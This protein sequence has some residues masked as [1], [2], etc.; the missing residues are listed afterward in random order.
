[1][2]SGLVIVAQGWCN[3]LVV[4]LL[5]KLQ[6]SAVFMEAKMLKFIAPLFATQDV[7]LYILANVFTVDL[8]SPSVVV[9]ARLTGTEVV[10]VSTI[11]MRSCAG[12]WEQRTKVTLH[13]VLPSHNSL[14][15]NLSN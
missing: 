7:K 11:P 4:A 6:V 14:S 1:M 9:V 2:P 12:D 8:P 3:V 10:W 15:P 13:L 5:L